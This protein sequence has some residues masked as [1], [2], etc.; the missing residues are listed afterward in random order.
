[1]HLCTL[2]GLDVYL[3]MDIAWSDFP[4]QG[5]LNTLFASSGNEHASMFVQLGSVTQKLPQTHVTNVIGG[6][7]LQLVPIVE[8]AVIISQLVFALKQTVL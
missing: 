7:L 5:E 4:F 8:K 6:C 2:F 1:M 3:G